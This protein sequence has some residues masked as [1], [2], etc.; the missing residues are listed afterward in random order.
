MWWG[1]GGVGWKGVEGGWGRRFCCTRCTGWGLGDGVGGRQCWFLHQRFGH[2]Y[3]GAMHG[4]SGLPSPSTTRCDC[5]PRLRA[6]AS[7]PHMLAPLAVLLWVQGGDCLLR[8]VSGDY[9]VG[10][11]FGVLRRL[12]G[13]CGCRSHCRAGVALG[14]LVAGPWAREGGGSSSGWVGGSWPSLDVASAWPW[15]CP[16][17]HPPTPPP[18]PHSHCLQGPYLPNYTPAAGSSP[19]T[20]G[21]QR[22]DHI[23]GL[24][25]GLGGGLGFGRWLGRW[26]VG[27]RCA[28]G[29]VP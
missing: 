20:Y 9:E 23:G 2:G 19:V 27:C 6:P 25:R 15:P 4:P 13:A 18:P 29:Q 3:M 21:L 1:G 24:G 12:G 26:G 28:E 7:L 5:L 10:L 17:P 11:G 16:P 22:M 14:L 8:F